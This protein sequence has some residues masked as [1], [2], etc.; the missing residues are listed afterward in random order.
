ME[1][2]ESTNKSQRNSGYGTLRGAVDGVP[3]SAD[4]QPSGELK[5]EGK[6][7]ARLLKDLL[8]IS[9]SKEFGSEEQNNYR[10][11]T[12]QY[13]GIPEEQVDIQMIMHFRQI[14]RAISKSDTYAYTAVM[15]RAFGKPKQQT[16]ITG[17]DG[18]TLQAVAPIFQLISTGIPLA[19]SE[20]QIS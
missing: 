20:D 18:Q 12:S 9:T 19:E 7:K 1:S 6:K 16:E 10:R 13:L 11:L 4:N 8:S 2:E 5:S 17:K 15:D 3:F 14:Q